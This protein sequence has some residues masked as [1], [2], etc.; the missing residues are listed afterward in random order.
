MIQ[1]VVTIKN[2]S[3][4]SLKNYDLSYWLSK[5]PEERVSAVDF[6]RRQYYG[7][8]VRLQRFARVVQRTRG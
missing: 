2:L 7:S 1:K 6:L 8:S 4:S 5:A 3:D